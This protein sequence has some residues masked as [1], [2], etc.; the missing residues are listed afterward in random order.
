MI[1][2]KGMSPECF[3]HGVSTDQTRGT[4]HNSDKLT[5][6]KYQ[7][8]STRAD[9]DERSRG[10][11]TRSTHD[12]LLLLA[13][14]RRLLERADDERRSRGH[15]RHGRL[16]VLDRQAHSHACTGASDTVS[17]AMRRRTQALPVAGRLRDVLADLL[18][19]ET[20][21]TNLGR[22]RRR[23]SD[24]AA[25]RAQVDDL[26]LVRVAARGVNR[27]ARA[28][29]PTDS[30]GA[31]ATG[32]ERWRRLARVS[33]VRSRECGRAAGRAATPSFAGAL[34]Q[35]IARRAQR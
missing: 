29:E 31:M 4:V 9:D 25:R 22:Q 33:A 34:R 18:G 7:A 20:E 3:C 27:A 10:R 11:G 14:S 12:V 5:L 26:D 24:L 15:D 17:R 19:R 30:L 13:V 21:R 16:T 35:L 2:S 1:W 28:S 23:C 8:I 32:I 6:R